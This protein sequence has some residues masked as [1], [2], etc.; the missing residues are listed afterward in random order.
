MQPYKRPGDCYRRA[1]AFALTRSSFAAFFSFS[2]FSLASFSSCKWGQVASMWVRFRLSIFSQYDARRRA[3]RRAHELVAHPSR[4]VGLAIGPLS[5]NTLPT[6]NI[7]ALV[8]LI[9]GALLLFFF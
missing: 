8:F 6:F 9:T 3:A 5:L 4:V 2:S 1:A 7:C